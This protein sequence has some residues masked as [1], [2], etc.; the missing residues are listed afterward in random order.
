MACYNA[1]GNI[2]KFLLERSENTQDLI[3][4]PINDFRSSTT[5]EETF[6]GL[7]NLTSEEIHTNQYSIQFYRQN[8]PKTIMYQHVI[9]LLIENK[10]KFSKNFI[11]DNGLSKLLAQTY[12]GQ[13]KD[14][15]FRHLL[16]TFCYLFKFKL[17]EIFFHD[18]HW[19]NFNLIEKSLSEVI[20]NETN[21]KNK[22]S[23]LE[24]NCKLFD[25]EKTIDE[26]LLN[27]FVISQ[28]VVK[29]HKRACMTKY[30]ELLFILH[31]SGQFKIKMSKMDYLKE[32]Y[33]ALY[34]FIEENT[35]SP[36]SLKWLGII[37]VRKTIGNLG[38]NKINSLQIPYSLKHNLFM[39]GIPIID[40]IHN[41]FF[42]YHF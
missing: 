12:V 34:N 16:D 37:Q 31:Y 4:T 5:L 19:Y 42:T 20:K 35:K 21:L 41:S 9:N 27:M 26:F 15:F 1:N 25:M 6:K 40:A 33:L 28:R 22:H 13:N 2:V 7:L 18:E 10:G 8:I 24:S 3:N 32:K 36:L 30:I 39:N 11:Q 14:I 17:N 38:V 29:D 23:Q